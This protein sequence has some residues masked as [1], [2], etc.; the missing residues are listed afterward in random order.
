MFEMCRIVCPFLLTLAA[1]ALAQ[2]PTPPAPAPTKPSAAEDLA[3]VAKQLATAHGFAAD[4]ADIK[5]FRAEIGMEPRQGDS[6][7]V[8]VEVDF[9][10]PRSLRCKVIEKGKR[11]ERGF[12]P[13]LGGWTISGDEI[14]KLQGPTYT[15]DA[16]QVQQELRLCQQLL[17]FLNPSRLVTSLLDPAPVRRE[18]L[19]ITE[20]L[21]FVGCTVIEGTVE[22]FPT[23]ALGTDQR[24]RVTLYLHPDTKRLLAV[25]ALPFDENDKP[26]ELAELVL[27]GDYSEKAGPWLP[28]KLTM[29]RL[30]GPGREI[31]M[32]VH[33]R[34]IELG[35]EFASQHFARPKK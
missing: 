28:T 9:L 24:T 19:K 13:K 30:A 29:Y 27:L 25:H 2:E 14:I 12:D 22:R 6:V 26:A 5:S 1:A 31:L 23:Y 7:G 21:I 15:Q 4:A 16:E 32:T 8:D 35:K 3:N 11:I 20:R 17:R 34:A 33:I 10:A 18:D